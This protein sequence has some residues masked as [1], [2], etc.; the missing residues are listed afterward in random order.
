[1]LAADSLKLKPIPIRL[2]V[3]LRPLGIPYRNRFRL[4][5]LLD[6]LVLN[7]DAVVVAVLGRSPTNRYTSDR[8]LH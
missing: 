8:N 3:S 2:D 1:M 4:I 6:T 7:I 5:I